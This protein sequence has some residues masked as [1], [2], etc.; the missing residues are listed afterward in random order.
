MRRAGHGKA[1]RGAS[2]VEFIV[3]LAIG[4]LLLVFVTRFFASQNRTYSSQVSSAELRGSLRAASDLLQR[5][6]RNAGYNPAGATFYG[7]PFDSLKLKLN[8]DLNGDGDLADTGEQVE[9]YLDSTTHEL[10]RGPGAAS[11]IAMAADVVM[12]GVD[13]FKVEFR[14]AAGSAITSS[15]GNDDIR[16]VRLRIKAGTSTRTGGVKA[17]GGRQ[18]DD[19]DVTVTPRNLG[20]VAVP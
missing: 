4:G 5:E 12:D 18:L 19:V 20:L 2:L 11:P 9:Y 13:T 8:A 15:A 10:K 14:N 17:Q 1:Q 7:V 6:V 3:A 16:Q